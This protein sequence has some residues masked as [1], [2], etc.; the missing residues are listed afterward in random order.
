MDP[1]PRIQLNPDLIRIQ[2]TFPILCNGKSTL[3]NVDGDPDVDVHELGLHGQ[4]EGVTRRQLTRWTAALY[5]KNVKFQNR[6]TLYYY[7]GDREKRRMRSY[8][9]QCSKPGHWSAMIFLSRIR[10]RIGNTDLDPDIINREK[11]SLFTLQQIYIC[12]CLSF[13]SGAALR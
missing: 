4:E 2:T 3:G 8:W 13:G 9:K 6:R 11:Y 10:I 7:T 5:K 1:D 12:T